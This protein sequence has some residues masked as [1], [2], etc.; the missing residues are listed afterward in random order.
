MEDKKEFRFTCIKCGNCCT[1]KNT[2]VNVTY[3]DILKIKKALNLS[4]DEIIEILGFYVFDKEPT[5]EE[6]NKMVIS[7]IETEKGLA[8]IG[9][10]KKSNGKCYFFNEKTIRCLIYDA[11]PMFCRT[12]PLSFRIIFDK[13]NKTKAK[14]IMSYTKKGK[15]YCPG[16][17]SVDSSIINENEWIKV[18]K[19][20]IEEMHDNNILIE[21]WNNM[22][23]KG[24]IRPSVR[25]FLMNILNLEEKN[26]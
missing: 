3:F 25:K 5:K 10:K 21:K 23:K 18:G 1:D 17:D 8:F 13:R 15:Q 16:I 20:T 19:K 4:L 7:P 11:R 9:L 14:I 6:L 2:L 26:N 12:F 24:Q 22:V